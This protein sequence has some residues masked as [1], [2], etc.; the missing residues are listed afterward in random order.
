MTRRPRGRPRKADFVENDVLP[1]EN[2]NEPLE[3]EHHFNRSAVISTRTFQDR[4]PEIA[5]SRN[6]P[7]CSCNAAETLQLIGRLS[8][9]VHQ[10]M[11]CDPH[12]SAD[13]L[14]SL[15][16]FN[17]LRAMYTNISLLGLTM[18]D[19][20]S[21]MVSGFSCSNIRD[22]KLPSPLPPSL[23]PT[24]LQQSII[25]HPWIDPFP[26]PAF[27][28]SL[29]LAS[30]LYDE[31]DLCNDLAGQCGNGGHGQVGIIIWGEPWDPHAWEMTEKFACKWYW[32]FGRCQELLVSTNYWR[33]QRGEPR[34]FSNYGF[35]MVPPEFIERL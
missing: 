23:A 34:M 19:I 5:Q 22:L 20:K 35:N 33:S 27:R 12:P 2:A 30:G 11:Q 31:E 1:R 10:G 9:R 29:L 13:M 16:Q 8:I 26:I 18:D 32:L 14:F 4:E 25:H 24:Q 3:N 15:T 28:D 21:D 7:I 17:V 6:L